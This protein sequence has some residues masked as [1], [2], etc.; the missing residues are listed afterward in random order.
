VVAVTETADVLVVG[1]GVAGLAC[2]QDLVAAGLRVRALEA[3][4]AVGGRMR[5]DVRDGFRFDRGFQVVNTSY[6][7]LRSRLRLK[8]LQLRPFTPGVLLHTPGGGCGS[9]T[10]AVRRGWPPTCCP[11]GWPRRA[12]SRPW[13]C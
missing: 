8:E 11:G 6:P 12:T 1:T 3:S 2:A 9:P 4:D 13:R 10:P 5:T 7:Q